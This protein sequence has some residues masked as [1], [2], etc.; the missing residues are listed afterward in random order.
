VIEDHSDHCISFMKRITGLIGLPCTK[1]N[2]GA[3][4][5]LVGNVHCLAS[6]VLMSAPSHMLV[7]SDKVVPSEC[8]NL[9]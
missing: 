9:I 2:G 6:N 1:L 4:K 3:L 5:T 8:K 7:S